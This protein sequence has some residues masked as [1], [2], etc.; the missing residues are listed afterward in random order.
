MDGEAHNM[1]A[2]RVIIINRTAQ[3]R[4]NMSGSPDTLE[5]DSRHI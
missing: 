4:D 2:V 1:R 5:K 3:L